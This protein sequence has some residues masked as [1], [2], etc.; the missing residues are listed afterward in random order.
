MPATSPAP[1]RELDDPILTALQGLEVDDP[2][3]Q[4]RIDVA[5]GKRIF[6]NRE[7]AI[8]LETQSKQARAALL[9]QH[10]AVKA[11][12]R[13]MER[14]I[15]ELRGKIVELELERNRR[16]ER[17]AKAL[18][19]LH[20]AENERK[21]LSKFATRAAI[22]KA[23]AAIAQATAKVERAN[24]AATEV[25]GWLNHEVLVTMPGL[26]AELDRIASEEVR[27][28]AILTGKSYTDSLGLV[29]PGRV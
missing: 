14:K 17:Q 8:L 19:E 2:Q 26:K 25:Q 1:A 3:V 5:I 20:A 6:A 21:A 15:G 10:E 29:H 18:S 28:D 13:A 11:E 16:A 23:D 7:A 24:A 12:G 4:Y 22:Q 27:I 9:E